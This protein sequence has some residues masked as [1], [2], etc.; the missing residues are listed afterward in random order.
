MQN[1]VTY[2]NLPVKGDFA[3]GVFLS[4][5]QNPTPPP[6]THCTSVLAYSI[7]TTTGKGGELN[8]REG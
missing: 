2:K 3:A 8:Q 1:L 7:L 4:K 5:A 6:L